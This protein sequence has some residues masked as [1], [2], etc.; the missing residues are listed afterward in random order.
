MATSVMIQN[1]VRAEVRQHEGGQPFDTV[2][3][4][5]NRGGTVT[6]FV[7]F[8]DGKSVADAINAAVAPAVEVA[9]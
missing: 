1:I 5:D 9:A 6:M 2:K 7:N 8:G 4:T 3:V